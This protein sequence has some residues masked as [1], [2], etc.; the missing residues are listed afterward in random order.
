MSAGG[1]Q[2]K[3]GRPGHP[4]QDKTAFAGA[5][6]VKA[7]SFPDIFYNSKKKLDPAWNE[8][9]RCGREETAKNSLWKKAQALF[10]A[11]T[12]LKLAK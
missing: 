12:A 1:A 7:N 2:L 11:S 8:T 10:T 5:E 4:A 6:Y 9:P 3:M